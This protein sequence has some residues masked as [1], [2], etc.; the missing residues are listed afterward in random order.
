MRVRSS[1]LLGFPKR[2]ALVEAACSGGLEGSAE[3]RDLGAP[4]GGPSR[5]DPPARPPI[6]QPQG[7]R[8]GEKTCK[9]RV[10]AR[11]REHCVGRMSRWV[12]KSNHERSGNHCFGPVIEAGRKREKS[13]P[14]RK[15]YSAR[16]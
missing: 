10:R 5:S 8:V 7:E 6:S 9:E 1:I 2:G 3:P 13:E 11:A 12:T 16:R 15:S 4:G 14:N